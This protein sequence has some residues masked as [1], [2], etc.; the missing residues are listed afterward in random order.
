MRQYAFLVVRPR[1]SSPNP[2]ISKPRSRTANSD[3]WSWLTIYL[4]KN[5][6]H[7]PYIPAVARQ[8]RSTGTAAVQ[9][10][11]VAE[12]S[13]FETGHLL[14]HASAR[15]SLGSRLPLPQFLPWR[16]RPRSEIRGL[17]SV[18]LEDM[19]VAMIEIS[20]A[21]KTA[22]FTFELGS[23]EN[24]WKSRGLTRATGS[25]VH[26]N[27]GFGPVSNTQNDTTLFTHHSPNRVLQGIQKEWKRRQPIFKELLK[28]VKLIEFSPKESPE[29]P[30]SG[31]DSSPRN[32][33]RVEHIL[34]RSLQFHEWCTSSTLVALLI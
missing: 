30:S 27:A 5:P 23:L 28:T 34:Q 15:F 20:N 1:L 12:A 18:A 24:G 22:E 2:N 31:Q 21:Y 3:F 11:I 14:A 32:A 8:T 19:H 25:S 16:S 17:L 9:E 33:R 10:G 4:P 13:Y 7:V 29:S 6:L 26:I